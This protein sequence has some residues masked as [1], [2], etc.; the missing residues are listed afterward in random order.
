MHEPLYTLSCMHR[1]PIGLA[2]DTSITELHQASARGDL[3][4][5]KDLIGE[6]RLD[7]LQK[8][9]QFGANALHYSA[10]YGQLRV[11]SYF[12]KERGCS[13]ASQDNRAM[14]PLHYAAYGQ[15]LDSVCYLVAEQQMDP[16]CC[17]DDGTTPL[18]LASH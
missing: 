17:A 12:I 15:H 8:E 1:I 5:V 18:H 10:L 16:L 14:T 9:D 3:K 4:K 6:K 7:P 13:P 2:H 11:L